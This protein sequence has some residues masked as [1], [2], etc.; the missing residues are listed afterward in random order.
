MLL[1]GGAGEGRW[2]GYSDVR[3]VIYRVYLELRELAVLTA[4]QR[5]RAGVPQTQ[6][7]RILAQHHASWRHTLAA[8]LAVSLIPC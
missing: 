6:A 4:T 7:Q 5:E 2:Q 3:D 1:V 8:V